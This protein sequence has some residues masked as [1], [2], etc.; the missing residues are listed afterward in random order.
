MK[1]ADYRKK[2]NDSI[3]EAMKDYKAD[4]AALQDVVND[5]NGQVAIT[6]RA[7]N[8]MRGRAMNANA[9]LIAAKQRELLLM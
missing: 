1:V 3:I 2:H 8:D 9:A 7:I 5:V 4:F 6:G